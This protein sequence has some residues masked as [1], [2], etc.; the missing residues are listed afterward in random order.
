MAIDVTDVE[1][2]LVLGCIQDTSGRTFRLPRV[3]AR[4]D[5]TVTCPRCQQTVHLHFPR[6]KNGRVKGVTI[7]SDH[8]VLRRALASQLIA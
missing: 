8:F 7:D 2:D 5:R 6:A 4:D 1:L 3:D